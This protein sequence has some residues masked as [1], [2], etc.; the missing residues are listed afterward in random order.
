MSSSTTTGV[1][2]VADMMSAPL[3][4]GCPQIRTEGVRTGADQT[5]QQQTIEHTRAPRASRQRDYDQEGASQ[6][7]AFWPVYPSRRPH[8]NPRKP[9]RDKFV[10]AVKRGIDPA[11][12]IRGAENYRAAIERAGTDPR[13]IAQAM[14]WLHQERWNDDQQAPE[15]PRLRF[16]MI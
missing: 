9:A 8:A 11:V 3:L 15:P 5:D 4:T 10:A 7:E 14:T 6:F 1:R 2:N 12:I 16:G 13:Y